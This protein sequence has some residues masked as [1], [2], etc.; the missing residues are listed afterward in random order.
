MDD[1]VVAKVVNMVARKA[2]GVHDLGESVSTGIDG[3]IA[4]IKISLV[5]EFGH[6]VKALAEQLRVDANRSRRAVPRPRC[7][8][9]GCSRHRHPPAGRRLTPTER[10]AEGPGRTR[11]LPPNTT[12][13][14]SA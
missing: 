5:V 4:T 12:P 3:D 9:G 13:G 1:V 6:P 11:G 10:P 14:S 7:R 2:E 8:G